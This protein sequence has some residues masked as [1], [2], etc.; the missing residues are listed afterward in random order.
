MPVT[1]ILN[2]V[3][4]ANIIISGLIALAYLLALIACVWQLIQGKNGIFLA[5][6]LIVTLI[7][8]ERGWLVIYSIG[9]LY[10][11]NP[12]FLAVGLIPRPILGFFHLIA[13][14][15]FIFIVR[16]QSSD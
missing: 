1:E 10:F 12:E 8:L 3:R 14:S 5:L 9:Q 6:L 13:I 15:F 16:W 2:I 7:M 4:W 11:T